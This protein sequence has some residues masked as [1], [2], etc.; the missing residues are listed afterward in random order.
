MKKLLAAVTALTVSTAQAATI[1]V[2]AGNCPGPGDGSKADPYCSIQTAIDNAVDTDEI[3]VAPGTYLEAINFLGK[4]VWLHTSGGPDVTT[5]NAQQTGTV[6]T[7]SS[8]EGPGTVLDG[9]TITGGNAGFGGG[10]YNDGSSPIVTDCTFNGNSATF[11]GGM[12][13]F[14]S[15]PTVTDCT[16]DGNAA[17]NSGGGMINLNSSPTVTNCT[18][19]GNSA[20]LGPP[21]CR[22]WQRVGGRETCRRG[23][24]GGARDARP[25]ALVQ[26]QLPRQARQSSGCA[27]AVERG[28]VGTA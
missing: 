1:H 16:F 3:I 23:C 28:R 8:G 20:V 21:A 2:D 18:F 13:N 27:G 5:I 22:A 4:A 26:W 25:G 24:R 12:N 6:V 11:G 14:T 17:G 19:S 9:F 15:N 10:M 7:C